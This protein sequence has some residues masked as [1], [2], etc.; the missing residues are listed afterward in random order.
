M[1]TKSEAM[2]DAGTIHSFLST[3]AASYSPEHRH[4]FDLGAY[5]NLVEEAHNEIVRLNAEV[6]AAR[7]LTAEAKAKGEKP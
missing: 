2:K 7:R 6:A 1:T 4:K 5:W 3:L